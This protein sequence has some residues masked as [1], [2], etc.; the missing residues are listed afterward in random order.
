MNIIGKREWSIVDGYRPPRNKGDG[1]NYL[2]HECVLILNR[3]EQDAHCSI[4]IYF[5]DRPPVKGIPFTAPAE[6]IS[7]FYTDDPSLFGGIGLDIMVQYSMH[8]TSDTDIIVQY[9]RMD[10]NQDNLA[11]MVTLGYPE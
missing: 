5:E 3:T 4:D 9:G 8:I 2:G 7:T 11:Y 1:K 6:R 10:I